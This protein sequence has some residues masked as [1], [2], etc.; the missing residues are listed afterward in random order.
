MNFVYEDCQL[1]PNESID[2]LNVNRVFGRIYDIT[3]EV[4]SPSSTYRFEPADVRNYGLVKTSRIYHASVPSSLEYYNSYY[5]AGMTVQSFWNYVSKSSQYG[6][7]NAVYGIEPPS[8]SLL[9][10][11]Y[12]SIDTVSSFCGKLSNGLK[13]TTVSFTVGIDHLNKMFGSGFLTGTPSSTTSGY[14]ASIS[15]SSGV[16]TSETI[17]GGVNLSAF[18]EKNLYFDGIP[19]S[20]TSTAIVYKCGWEKYSSYSKWYVEASHNITLNLSS[21][22]ANFSGESIRTWNT[23]GTSSVQEQSSYVPYDGTMV[24]RTIPFIMF[25]P[26]NATNM[27][28]YPA[29]CRY[30]YRDTSSMTKI[31]DES[32]KIPM[33]PLIS[34]E[35]QSSPDDYNPPSNVVVLRK[36]DVVKDSSGNPVNDI[37]RMQLTT[38]FFVGGPDDVNGVL[39]SSVI[40]HRTIV[41]VLMMG[42]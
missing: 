1:Y 11:P 38:K 30:S 26:V 29:S 35:S 28:N 22:L 17:T 27:F 32:I 37:L 33:S 13:L 36:F 20:M 21:L 39:D 6:S 5:H 3:K 42:V 10:V 12:A 8:E 34:E 14:T 40:N 23:D 41:N 16:L 19:G 9:N 4:T 18:A 31:V 24:Y 2:K 25:Q 7:H 15:T